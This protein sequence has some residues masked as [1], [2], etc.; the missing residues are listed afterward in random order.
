MALLVGHQ[1]IS[2]HGIDCTKS[3]L[4]SSMQI[5]RRYSL[6]LIYHTETR[7]PICILANW[8]WDEIDAILQTT[9]SNAFSRMKS[10]IFWLKFHWSLFLGAQFTITQHWFRKWRSIIWTNDVKISSAKWR[11]FCH[12]VLTR[13]LLCWVSPSNTNG[14]F[15]TRSSAVT[16]L[17]AR[18][19]Y[20]R[21]PWAS[22]QIRKIAGCACAGDTRNVFPVTAG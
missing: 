1:V 8:G 20:H 10:F 3:I 17:I 11:P 7:T 6:Y 22:Y 9:F 21:H 14:R 4:S 18:K 19:E 16:V 5:A 12:N 15:V 2:S 13:C